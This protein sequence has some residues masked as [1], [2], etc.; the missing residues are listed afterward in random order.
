M[1]SLKLNVLN[2]FEAEMT[3]SVIYDLFSQQVV[4]EKFKLSEDDLP[5]IKDWI[6]NSNIRNY[7]S[8]KQKAQLGFEEKIGNTWF[9]GMN[10][11]LSGYLSDSVDDTKY[12]SS[13]GDIAGQEQLFTQF[14]NFLD[15]WYKAYEKCQLAQTPQAWFVIIQ[16]LCKNILY[17]DIKDD[18][19]TRIL[20]QLESK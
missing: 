7:Y 2:S 15:Q 9:F 5:R 12:L 20:S 8:A 14:F 11:W 6:I 18:F 10:R 19:E 13:F 17:N 3:A 16:N 1:F 4:F